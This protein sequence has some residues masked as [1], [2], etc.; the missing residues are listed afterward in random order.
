MQR[1]LNQCQYFSL[2]YSIEKISVVGLSNEI[3]FLSAHQYRVW[4]D[5][6]D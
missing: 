6:T 1:F 3:L 5:G 4:L 2:R